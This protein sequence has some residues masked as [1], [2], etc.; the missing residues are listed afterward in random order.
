M[1]LMPMPTPKSGGLEGGGGRAPAC[2]SESHGS[3]PDL[4]WLGLE[5]FEAL[6]FEIEVRRV[7]A[8]GLQGKLPVS[9]NQSPVWF[10]NHA[11]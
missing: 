10:M 6:R 4:R 8:R 7:G 2:G 3:E 9:R 11:G 1:L 5:D